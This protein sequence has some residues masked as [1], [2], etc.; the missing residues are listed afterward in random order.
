KTNANG[1]FGSLLIPMTPYQRESMQAYVNRGYDLFTH[2]CAQGRG[3]S[4]D[5][6]KT[7]AEGRVWDG[8]TALEIGLVDKLGSLDDAIAKAA[9][10]Q[11][12]TSSC[13]VEEYPEVKN[14]WQRMF[15]RYS[16]DVA[17]SKLREQL[18]VLYDYQQVLKQVLGRQQVLCLMEPIEIK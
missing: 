7:I 16:E 13:C 3:V 14:R 6:I 12:G 9:E 11:Y 5:S 1:E 4:Q 8:R 15:E 10:L 2:R 17:E 18:G